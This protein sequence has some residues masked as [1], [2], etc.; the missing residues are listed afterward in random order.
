M[1]TE[2]DDLR[3]QL[4]ARDAT[5]NKL[6]E[7]SKIDSLIIGKAHADI[8][9]RDATIADLTEALRIATRSADDQMMQKREA[10]ATIAGLREALTVVRDT[11]IATKDSLRSLPPTGGSVLIYETPERLRALACQALARVPPPKPDAGQAED[12]TKRLDWLQEQGKPETYEDAPYSTV[13]VVCG[14]PGQTDI[15][16]AIDAAAQP[17][18]DTNQA[19]GEAQP[20]DTQ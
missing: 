16:A 13:W 12:D 5:I 2:L 11:A 18:H 1:S 7:Q 8:L 14:D 20:K 3:Q 15:R 4:A 9:A 19:T 10:Q 17:N 6:K